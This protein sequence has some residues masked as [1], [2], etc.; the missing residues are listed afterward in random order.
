M[1]NCTTDEEYFLPFTDWLINRSPYSAAFTTNNAEQV[2]EDRCFVVNIDCPSNI[3]IGGI[4]ASRSLWEYTKV[5]IGWFELTKR[6]CNENLAFLLAQY[7]SISGDLVGFKVFDSLHSAV[8]CMHDASYT[9]NFVFNKPRVDAPYKTKATYQG[10]TNTWGG[11]D[12]G[13]D[14][15]RQCIRKVKY[16]TEVSTN[17]FT[18]ALNKDNQLTTFESG[19]SQLVAMSHEIMEKIS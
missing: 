4:V 14:L 16:T 19:F 17:P 3:M 7:T 10:I 8:I 12:G 9:H 15:I 6:G 18:A 13:D 2:K 11:G 1:S 5:A